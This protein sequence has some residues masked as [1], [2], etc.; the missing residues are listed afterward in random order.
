MDGGTTEVTASEG[1]RG[2]TCPTLLQERQLW[3]DGFE[4]LAGLDEAGRGALAGPVVAAAAILPFDCAQEGV[5]AA[6]H[7]S[8]QITPSR[9]ERLA[10]EIQA[11]AADWKLG[12]ASAAEIDA[13]GIAPA[14]RLAMH[15]AVLALDP[16][17]DHLLID[18]VQ[19]RALNTPQQSFTRGD[20]RVVSIAAASILAKVHR[21]RLLRQLHTAYPEYGFAGHK[22]Y[23]VQT[24]L[25]AIARFGPCPVHRRS[26]APM[27]HQAGLFGEDQPPQSY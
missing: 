5:W 15:R 13:I 12:E 20:Q 22:G 11:Q 8:K 25:E 17:P 14:T 23:G 6:V 26:F 7:D 2:H 18:W 3:G 9:R 24:H 1:A 27:R 4:R 10:E 19:L 21:D 16:P